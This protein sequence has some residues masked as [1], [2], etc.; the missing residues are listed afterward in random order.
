M[1]VRRLP[2]RLRAMCGLGFLR[3]KRT[4][5]AV[6]LVLEVIRRS[7]LFSCFVSIFFSFFSDSAFIAETMPASPFIF[8]FSP[9]SENYD[10]SFILDATSI[11]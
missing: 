2:L 1:H 4:T 6:S 8:I 11:Q 10:R 5:H 7:H 9:A 3:H